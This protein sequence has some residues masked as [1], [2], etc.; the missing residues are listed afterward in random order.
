VECDTKACVL[1]DRHHGDAAE[2]SH[3]HTAGVFSAKVR[4]LRGGTSKAGDP[5]TCKL[6]ILG[7]TSVDHPVNREHTD[8]RPNV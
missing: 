6:N 3:W 8:L 2:V 7:V 5:Q 4:F 1:A